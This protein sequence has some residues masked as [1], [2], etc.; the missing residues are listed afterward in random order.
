MAGTR[1][2]SQRLLA[3]ISEPRTEGKG[4]EENGRS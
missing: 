2:F 3:H 1:T 4:I